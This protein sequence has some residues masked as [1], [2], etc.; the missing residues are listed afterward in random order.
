MKK[1]KTFTNENNQAFNYIKFHVLK[2]YRKSYLILAM[3]STITLLKMSYVSSQAS[4]YN[5]SIFDYFYK[6]FEG[7]R[8]IITSNSDNLKLPIDWI[9]ICISYIFFTCLFSEDK[10]NLSVVLLKKRVKWLKYQILLCLLIAVSFLIIVFTII[11]IYYSFQCRSVH[12]L[13]FAFSNKNIS[14]AM[15]TYINFIPL[16]LFTISIISHTLSLYFNKYVSSITL[17]I[18]LLSSIYYNSPLLLFYQLLY[19][20]INYEPI[21]YLK[22][23]ILL[24][25]FIITIS[26][27]LDYYKINKIDVL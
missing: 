3:I 8:P 10:M 7:C 16:T 17:L 6:L 26:I 23:Y 1:E 5:L 12:F 22:F 27:I 14:H 13:L 15:I 4:N 11:F 9:F 24:N 19:I 20:R 25:V 21:L 2:N 18:L